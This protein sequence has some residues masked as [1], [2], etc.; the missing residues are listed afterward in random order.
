MT[1]IPRD[2]FFY[3]ILTQIKDWISFFLLTIKFRIFYFLKKLPEVPDY[4]E[5]WHI[6]IVSL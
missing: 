5:M 2:I 3:P 4:P 6:V 1:V